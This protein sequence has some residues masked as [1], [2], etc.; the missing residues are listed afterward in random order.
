M[1]F[2]LVNEHSGL[3]LT[4]GQPCQQQPYRNQ[5]E[6]RFNLRSVET[7]EISCHVGAVEFAADLQCDEKETM[8]R[9]SGCSLWLLETVAPGFV[10]VKSFHEPDLVL[11]VADSSMKTNA[12]VEMLP[13]I[14]PTSSLQQAQA[15]TWRLTPTN[16]V[17]FPLFTSSEMNLFTCD[18]QQIETELP[19]IIE[20]HGFCV[21]ENVLSA[22]EIEASLAAWGRDLLDTI[23]FEELR[24]TCSHM[25]ATDGRK[26]QLQQIISNLESREHREIPYLYPGVGQTKMDFSRHSNAHGEFAWGIRSNLKVREVFKTMYQLKENETDLVVGMDAVFFNPQGAPGAQSDNIWGHADQ[27]TH[28]PAVVE[29]N[30]YQGV[31]AVWDLDTPTCSTTVVWP[32]SHKHAFDKLMESPRCADPCPHPGGTTPCARQFVELNTLLEPHMGNIF[33]NSY[34]C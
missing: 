1:L 14:Y 31:V 17:L 2:N 3:A 4:L 26:S 7:D 10:V 8:L 33:L 11:G 23:D 25:A 24:K 12:R 30:V 21:I 5:R 22:S 16:P 15:Q 20:E 34:V 19:R 29:W 6:Q 28:E 9:V 27:N 18:Y 32:G 13:R